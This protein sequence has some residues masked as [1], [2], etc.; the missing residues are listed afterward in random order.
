MYLMIVMPFVPMKISSQVGLD[1]VS[2]EGGEAMS[3]VPTEMCRMGQ[4]VVVACVVLLDT[5]FLILVLSLFMI[6]T[7]SMALIRKTE[8]REKGVTK[9]SSLKRAVKGSILCRTAAVTSC[10][11]QWRH[12]SSTTT[13][14]THLL[15]TVLISLWLAE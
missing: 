10:L 11:Q 14:V 2:A 12:T 9:Q 3:V 15:P 7:S 8:M 1:N 5:C 6:I 13:V 4:P